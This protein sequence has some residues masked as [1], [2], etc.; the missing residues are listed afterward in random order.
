MDVDECPTYMDVELI[1]KEE[2]SPVMAGME[3][4]NTLETNALLDM[5]SRDAD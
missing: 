1:S 2:A 3:D 5:A 4:P